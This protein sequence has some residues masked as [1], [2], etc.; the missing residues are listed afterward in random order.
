MILVDTKVDGC[1]LQLTNFYSPSNREHEGPS[2]LRATQACHD[3]VLC[4]AQRF[5]LF[6]M[7]AAA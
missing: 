2:Q 3:S 4:T 1:G 6:E 5:R 7:D